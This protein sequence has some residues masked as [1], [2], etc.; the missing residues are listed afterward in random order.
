MHFAVS[1]TGRLLASTAFSALA[2]AGAAYAQGAEQ[3][4]SA[5]NQSGS[6]AGGDELLGEVV[7]TAT[8][9]TSTVNRVPLSVS[10]VGQQT[11]DQQG[12]KDVQDLARNVP[13]VTFG[14]EGGEQRTSPFDPGHR[15][16]LGSPTTGV[17]LDDV[18]IQKR[19][20]NGAVDR[21][22]AR[23]SRSCS[24]STASRSCA[25]RRAPSTA[26]APRAAPSASSPRPRA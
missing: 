16:N 11:M 6:V 8:R 25:A 18:P 2:I 23:P 14:R 4:A 1:K 12:I 24:T 9:Q 21:A 22:T 17:Y 5:Q 7:V 10:A 13:G 19:D 26:A 3:Q 20:T 15:S